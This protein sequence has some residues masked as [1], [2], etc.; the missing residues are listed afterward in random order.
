MPR[1]MVLIALAISFLASTS[2][3]QQ[4]KVMAPHRR[5]PT[6]VP[7]SQEQPLP[8]AKQ[9]SLVG[10]LWMTDPNLKSSLYLKNVVEISAVTVTPILYL[11]NGNKFTLP[12]VTL[13]PSGTAVVD[14]NA[15]IQ[16]LGIASYA[17]LSGYVEIQYNW[18]WAPVCATIRVVDT[19]HSVIFTYGVRPSV[20]SS[21]QNSSLQVHVTSVA[22]GVWWK[23]ESNVTGF[24]ALAN[25]SPNAV[26]AV[27][28]VTDSRGVSLAT[29]TVTVSAHGTK[30]VNLPELQA[31]PSSGGGIHV[32][33]SGPKD[34]L[35]IN[36]GLEDQS[37]GYSANLRFASPPPATAKVSQIT[38]A[39]LGLMV[40]AADP[41]MFFPGGTTFTPYS[42]LRNISD[43]PLTV[44]PTVW[45][46]AGGSARSAPL[47]GLTIA[48]S[49][50]Q[51]LDVKSLI[52]AA[53]LGN[54]NGSV[55]LE[56]SVQGKEGG[57]LLQGGSVDQSN[58]YVF[59]VNPR[60]VFDSGSKSLGY[61]STA[62]GDDTMVTLWNPADEAQD[63]VFRVVF[64][65][66]HYLLPMHFGPRE[67]HGFN[68][69][70][71]IRNQV[72]DAEGNIIPAT[73][74]EGSATISGT[75]EVAEHILVAVDVGIYNV[76]KATCGGGCVYC[77]G[78]TSF[79]SYP[80]S[81]A[82]AV[83]RTQQYQAL[84][85]WSSGVQ[86]NVANSWSS[87]HTSIAT[88]NSNGLATGVSAGVAQ[89]S[90][91]FGPDPIYTGET[92]FSGGSPFCP[93]PPA[94]GTMGGT[95]TVQ[96]PTASRIT[97][98]LSSH[99]ITSS[100]FPTCTS[101]QAGWYRQVMK[102][103]TDQTGADIVLS[104]QQLNETVTIGTPNNLNVGGVQTGTATTDANGNFTDT[105]F[106]C[107][108]NCPAS[109]GQTNASQ[110]ITDVLPSGAGPYSLSTNSLVYKCT[111][112]TVNGQ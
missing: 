17:T 61:W 34:A 93:A 59:E 51:S 5:I 98:T 41:M 22:E 12:D 31:A 99:S 67:T 74:Q 68:M 83:Q 77:D 16:N 81:A 80:G 96:V 86:Y 37:V 9:G 58:T 73:V 39:E 102:I 15:A 26:P 66:G 50:S 13:E 69:S 110:T 97:Q 4:P 44:T 103:V 106:V 48:P 94:S 101:T 65:G 11:S 89:F 38:F 29:H 10:G 21:G 100:N 14:I 63:L 49:Q 111:G 46:M 52:S 43:A 90:A 23:Q 104:G 35:E 54:F 75:H 107:S 2:L 82:F 57:L 105:F 3:A 1:R 85:T 18:P 25:T 55:N 19:V 91:P 109:T 79:G 70:E 32:L 28:G 72:P 42:V 47:Q 53:G 40:G 30:I 36:G 64:S 87:N 62:N 6:R 78:Y 95:G 60:G 8:P 112:I 27:I 45:W 76:R 108:P 20:T 24:V 56:F 7:K 92:C 33:Y 71:I 88:I 84:G